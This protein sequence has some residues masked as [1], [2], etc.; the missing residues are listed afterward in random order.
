MSR[1]I[2]ARYERHIAVEF[3]AAIDPELKPGMQILDVGSGRSPALWPCDRPSG[4]RYAGLDISASELAYAPRGSYT[5]HYVAD[6]SVPLAELRDQFDL[7]VSWQ[8]LEHVRDIGSA[9]GNLHAYLRSGGRLVALLSGRYSVFG[10]LN[11]VIPSTAGVA[12]MRYLLR[13]DPESVFPAYYDRC[14]ANALSGLLGG[15]SCSSVQP[16]YQGGAYF[17]FAPALR[18]LY[19]AYENWAWRSGKS[20]LATHYLVVAQR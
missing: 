8:V 13:R 16:L 3:A 15:W 18:S 5:D 1:R 11:A 6:V 2:P 12:M 4:A 17:N 20:N 19:F 7:I 10:V 9:L 14:Y